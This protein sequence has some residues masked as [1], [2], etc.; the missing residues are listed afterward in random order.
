VEDWLPP[1]D[2]EEPDEIK[3]AEE[4]AARRSGEEDDEGT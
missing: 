3:D 4:E 2:G 1:L